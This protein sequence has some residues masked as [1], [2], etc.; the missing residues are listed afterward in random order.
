MLLPAAE[1][2]ALPVG[3]RRG[4]VLPGQAVPKVFDQLKALSPPQFED[5]REFGVHEGRIRGFREWFKVG[6]RAKG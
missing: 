3:E 5:L 2:V 4:I 6:A 1:F